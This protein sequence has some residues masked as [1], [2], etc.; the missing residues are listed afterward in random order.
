MEKPYD[1]GIACHNPM[2]MIMMYGSVFMAV[3]VGMD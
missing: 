3:M 1:N 2:T